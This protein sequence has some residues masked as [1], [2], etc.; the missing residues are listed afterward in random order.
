M[1]G[2]TSE[3]FGRAWDIH[4]LVS[5]VNADVTRNFGLRALFLPDHA[6]LTGHARL[7][8]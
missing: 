2:L 7:R 6:L 3:P 5:P 1:T 4:G 8:F